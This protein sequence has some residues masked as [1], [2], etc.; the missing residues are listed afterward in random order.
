MS[1]IYPR[2]V[3]ISRPNI[4]TAPGIQQYG[5]V[6]PSDETAI[7]SGLPASIQLKKEKGQP[8]PA[9]P[10]DAAAKTFW[11]IFI[12]AGAA[13]LGLIMS[14]DI[15]TDDLSVRYQVTGPYWNSLGYDLLC[16]RLE[17]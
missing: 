16:E 4:H 2:T 7:A 11:S 17:A 9:L 1:F 6:L 13:A 14:R 15:I 3:A 10:A 12:P 5:G 8:D